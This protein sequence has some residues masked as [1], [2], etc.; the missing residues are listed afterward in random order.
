MNSK[1][2]L[3]L[4]TLLTLLSPMPVLC[5]DKSLVIAPD[6]F[7]DELKPL[8]RFKDATVRPTTLLSLND[9]YKNFNGVDKPEQIK[10][11]IAHHEDEHGVRFVMLVGDVD[12]FPVRWRWWGY[13]GR[14]PDG[15][16]AYNKE[17]DQR[18]WAV[19]DLYYADLYKNGTTTFDDWDSN[20]NGLYG[21]IEFEPD[22]IDCFFDCRTINNDNIDFLPDVSV[23]RI[24]ASTE[25]EVTAYVNKVIAYETATTPS[26]TWFKT[27]GLYTGC[28]ISTADDTKDEIGTFLTSKGFTVLPSS[29]SQRIRY[30][31]WHDPCPPDPAPCCE[32]PL[33]MPGTIVSDFDSG[34]GFA[35]YL[36]HGNIWGWA[37]LGF[38]TAQLNNLNNSGKLPVAFGGACDTG[39]FA[40]MARGDHYID[41]NNV[42]HC[43]GE[44]I[45]DLY[46][47]VNLPRPNPLQ[48][49]K[50]DC[51]GE[52]HD[53]DKNCFAENLLF[54]FGNASGQTPSS[55]GAIAYLGARSGGQ[56]GMPFLDKF[57]FQAYKNGNEI[58]GDMWKEMVKD[59]YWDRKLDQSS[60][61]VTRDDWSKGH[62][63]DEP[64]KLILFGDP[65]LL[66]GGA[67]RINRCGTVYDGE[68]T[69]G[70]LSGYTRYR[71]ECDVTV[72]LGEKLTIYPH[73]SILFDNG[74]KITAEAT[75]LDEG[76]V[77][78]GASDMP[79]NF[80]SLAPEPQSEHAVQ[81]MKLTGQLR[82]R[83]GGQIKLY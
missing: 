63:F 31:H 22:P 74:K 23:G 38:G 78:N 36:G 76:L 13:V 71:V 28:W 57:F 44:A 35:N 25:A 30:G 16:L 37:C 33:N 34:L 54:G 51:D 75:G 52:T 20:N 2:I 60:T 58:L 49:G 67:F 61:W 68:F 9:V 6:V 11:C 43:K 82:I 79:I 64:Q 8:K 81:G 53:L 83:N 72:P 42:K 47:Y 18:G 26:E 7:I 56:W 19:S 14:N 15:T 41:T 40:R 24:P 3:I 65:S 55:N 77:M 27:V 45:N 80:L 12:Q 48:K 39:M 69:G 29:E 5:Q 1:N 17:G 4:A 73:A 62:G 50:I 46:P 66:V 70:P 59:Y 32:P 10:R 21:E